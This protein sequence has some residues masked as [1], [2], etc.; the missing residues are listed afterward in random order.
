VI[1]CRGLNTLTGAGD[2][3]PAP[4]RILTSS[5]KEVRMAWG[6]GNFENDRAVGWLYLDFHMP[7]VEKIRS[8]VAHADERAGNEIMAAVEVMALVCEQI[9][10]NYLHP[11]HVAQWRDTFLQSWEVYADEICG[12]SGFKEARRSQIVRSFGRLLAVGEE[13]RRQAVAEAVVGPVNLDVISEEFIAPAERERLEAQISAAL[14][15]AGIGRILG[16]ALFPEPDESNIR[17]RIPVVVFE[18]EAGV[19]VLRQVL[20][21]AEVPAATWIY[22]ETP[23]AYIEI[24]FDD[25]TPPLW[26]W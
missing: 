19:R 17:W 15:V 16:S 6:S 24:W 22:Q 14:E 8:G 23:E 11:V 12:P 2:T 9:R 21:A 3:L 25:N 10:P 13:F 26:G 7:L 20:R 1:P 4:V 5:T 18:H